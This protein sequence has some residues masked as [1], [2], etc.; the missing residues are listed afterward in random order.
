MFDY[1]FTKTHYTFLVLMIT[2]IISKYHI[3]CV[4]VQEKFEKQFSGNLWPLLA[5]SDTQWTR[6]TL[7]VCVHYFILS[8]LLNKGS[9]S[10]IHFNIPHFSRMFPPPTPLY[11]CCPI[12]GDFKAVFRKKF[13]VYYRIFKPYARDN[14][15]L[16]TV[17]S[18]VSHSVFSVPHNVFL[19]CLIQFFFS[20]PL[21][22]LQ[23]LTQFFSSVSHCFFFSFS[24]IFIKL[25][26]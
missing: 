16:L 22:F 6:T 20:V 13:K 3:L 4:E 14:S 11:A 7:S 24:L 5:L 26:F 23:F 18:A 12:P 19:K 2:I 21:C 17:C 9:C 15:E 10:N 8:S 25:I 1:L